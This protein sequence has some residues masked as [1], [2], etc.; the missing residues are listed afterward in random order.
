MFEGHRKWIDLLNAQETWRTDD[1]MLAL[2]PEA[3]REFSSHEH[4]PRLKALAYLSNNAQALRMNYEALEAGDPMDLGLLTPI[5]EGLALGLRDW[6]REEAGRDRL[7]AA[8]GRG[9]QPSVFTLR[10]DA[11]S[12]NRGTA[13]LRRIIQTAT[14][15]FSR[16]LEMRLVDVSYPAAT[17]G[18]FRVL[19]CAAAHCHTLVAT[20]NGL[21]IF[22]SDIC[23]TETG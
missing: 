7:L 1:A 23:A 17:P 2:V 6:R 9:S 11:K 15:W 3:Q 16:Y 18:L 8:L 21:P 13:A 14:F 12:W 22:C 10:P 19:P 5:L 4:W 20:P